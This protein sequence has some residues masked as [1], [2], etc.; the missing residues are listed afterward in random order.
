MIKFDIA[1]RRTEVVAI[2]VVLL[3]TLLRLPW[4]A[5]QSIAFDESFSL[6][7]GLADIST[8]FQAILSDGVHPPLFYLIYKIAL[9]LW[10]TSEFGQRFLA[11]VF[12]LLSIA[13]VYKIGVVLFNR[14]VGLLSA[15]LLAFNP[16]HI[17]FAQEARMYSLFGALTI[18][19]MLAFWQALRTNRRRYWG[20]LGVSHSFI[21]LLH[22]FGFLLPF[23]QFV[24]IISTF[25]RHHRYL[26]RWVIVQFIAFLPLLPW[27]IATAMREAQT[28]GIGFLVQPNFL[29]LPITFWNMATGSSTLLGLPTILTTI[30][31]GVTLGLAFGRLAPFEV[32]LRQARQLVGFW[33]VLPPVL[34]WLISQRRS[35]Y[36]DR[37]LSFV[38]PA[39]VLL[40]AYGVSRVKFRWRNLLIG[41]LVAVSAYSLVL[42]RLD[43]AFQKDDWRGLAAYITRQEQSG[44]V[45][46]L[47]TTHI[48]LPFDYYYQGQIPQKPISLNLERFPIRPLL[49]G[50]HRA[51][52]VY[53]YTRRPT[54]YPMQPLM[55]NGYWQNDPDRN[56]YLQQW[57]ETQANKIIDY[58]HFLGIE[59]WL[60]NLPN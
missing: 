38:I 32:Y 8:L 1:W 24:F 46:L 29:D 27:L 54:H 18:V 6:A 41:I 25:S 35:F 55:I 42:T 34:T 36:S 4:L 51:W 28:F 59:L 53:P 16:L 31:I 52:V 7:V 50:Y 19:S 58:Q 10:G 23:I 14:F 57:F 60:V 2:A 30:I 9:T 11:A 3:A 12:S 13:L 21:F 20:L 44:D 39:L 15:L 43:P 22:Y 56:P 17:W 26:R 37:Y 45:I 5:T 40:L 48:K 33:L 47:Y 49:Q